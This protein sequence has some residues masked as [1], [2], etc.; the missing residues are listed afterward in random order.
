MRLQ[1][2][3]CNKYVPPDSYFCNRCGHKIEREVS[4]LKFLDKNYHDPYGTWQVTTEGDVEGRSI[5]H[6]GTY[7]GF[8]DD[9]AKALASEVYYSLNFKK[10][11]DVKM[12][13]TPEREPGKV[14]IQLDI[15]SKTWDLKPEQR[16]TVMA[17]ALKDRPVTVKQGQYYASFILEF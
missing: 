2:A 4:L 12:L 10:V 7:E 3:S 8:I 17:E 9:I 1:C 16:A 13:P 14:S 15:G 11:G 6:L 5:R